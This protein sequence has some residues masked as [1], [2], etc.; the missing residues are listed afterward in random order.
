MRIKR[1]GF[2]CIALVTSS[3]IFSQSTYS[4][5]YNL[6][7]THCTTGCHSGATPDAQLDLSALPAVVYGNLINKDAVNETA[8][9]KGDKLVMPGYPHR[10]FLLRKC[11]NAL[12]PENGIGDNEGELMPDVNN[13]LAPQEIELLRQWILH[14]AP[15]VGSPV[16]T[17]IINKYYRGQGYASPAVPFPMPTVPGSFQIHVGKIFVAPSGEYQFYI[18]H[19]PQLRETV[20]VYR[21]DAMLGDRGHHFNMLRFN[22][23]AAVSFANGI[24][25]LTG[26]SHLSAEV[27]GAFQHSYDLELP[28]GTAYQW[29]AGI[30]LDINFH[31]IN[32]NHDSVLAVDLYINVYTQPA[33]TADDI[34]KI[35]WYQNY[36]FAIPY[37]NA[38]H[39][40]TA[41]GNEPT[42]TDTWQIWMMS[43]HTHKYGTDFDIFMRNHDGSEGQQ[44]YEGHYNDDYTIPQGFYDWQH[45]PRRYFNPFLVVDPDDGFIYK[46]TYKNTNG[47]SLV[48]FGAT[49]ADEMM[50]M[51]VHYIEKE[52]TTE[53]NETNDEQCD[54]TIFPNP[55][56]STSIVRFSLNESSKVSL[57]ILNMLGETISTIVEE[58]VPEGTHSKGIF[59]PQTSGYYFA[60]ITANG[61]TRMKPFIVAN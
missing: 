9:A 40:F 59:T 3:N 25:D 22:P 11:D 33:G 43:S 34:M 35:R 38:E 18:K 1:I 28:Q 2:I 54:L 52:V 5:V 45:P 41:T 21:M 49:A 8:L 57:E 4:L 19:D 17:S 36:L 48:L 44:V 12:D 51:Y 47:P 37:D 30:V 23:G 13:P 14:G 53:I 39:V 29:D 61:K 55:V 56:N 20:E 60:R 6:F 26:T 16:D 46:T 31:I 15:Q 10:S 32:T 50:I 58:W 24:R 7:Q 42:P 27:I